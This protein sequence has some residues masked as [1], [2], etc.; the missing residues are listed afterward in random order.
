MKKEYFVHKNTVDEKLKEIKYF[1]MDNVKPSFW[2]TIEPV[3]TSRTAQQNSFW[4]GPVLDAFA[5]LM[6]ETDKM[7]IKGLL[8]EKFLT[9]DAGLGKTYIQDTSDLTVSEMSEFIDKCL[10]LLVDMGGHLTPSEQEHFN[11][12]TKARG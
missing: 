1:I 8:K 6:G 10:N 4:H 9:K 5:R 12:Y 11:E 2:I 7:Y 3:S